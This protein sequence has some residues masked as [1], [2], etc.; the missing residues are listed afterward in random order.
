VS[1]GTWRARLGA[2]A[3]VATTALALALDARVEG[4]SFVVGWVA[5][6]PWLMGLD[7]ICTV[8]SAAAQGWLM[9][10]A[11]VAMVF[12]WF[13]NAIATYTGLPWPAGLSLALGIAPLLEPQFVTYAAVHALVGVWGGG[14]WSQ[15]F[16]GAC[17][18][19]GTEWAFPKLFADTLGHGLYPSPLMRQAADL[20][21]AHGLTFVLLLANAGVLAVFRALQPPA[22]DWRRALA[23]G[24]CIATLV[25]GLLAY[26]HVRY[27]Q[28]HDD[29]SIAPVA[30]VAVQTDLSN[31][32]GMAAELGTYDAVRL[33][34]NTHVALSREALAREPVDLLI[35]PETVYPTTFGSPK[36]PDGAAFDHEISAFADDIGVPLIFGSYDA[37]AGHEYNAAFFLEPSPAHRVTFEAYR[38]RWLFPLIEHV[39]ARFDSPR[40]RQWFPWLGTWQPGAGAQVVPLTLRDGRTLRIAPL[41]CYD[42]LDPSLVIS[43]VRR[44]A[45]LIVTLSNDSWFTFGNAPRLVLVLSAFRTLETRRPQVRATNTGISAVVTPTGEMPAELGVHVRGAL[46]HALRPRTNEWTLMLAWGDWLPPFALLVGGIA[47]ANVGRRRLPVAR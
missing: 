23:P 7:R 46:T 33:I 10:V 4:W 45:D 8:R 43:S 9:S 15:A 16:I 18:Y 26:G 12:H 19:V 25:G 17:A 29:P 5:L 22:G 14:F 38:K 42:A 39:P 47:L 27:A 2:I 30:V 21:G 24:A 31:Y 1:D 13:P 20:A 6:V 44:G 11:F 34:L 35:W 37:E 3:A 40:V 28:L 32:A 41:I 36:S